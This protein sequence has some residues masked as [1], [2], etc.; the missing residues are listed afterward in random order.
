MSHRRATT[1]TT[2]H[3]S[4]VQVNAISDHRQTAD[5]KHG[6]FKNRF[7]NAIK[8]G[9]PSLLRKTLKKTPKG[10]RASARFPKAL[11]S[12]CALA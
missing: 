9:S 4:F 2:E 11:A 12:Q 1:P 5:R 8:N 10:E 7:D 6:F 3:R